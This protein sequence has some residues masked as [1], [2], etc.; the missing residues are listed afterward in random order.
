MV[1]VVGREQETGEDDIASGIVGPLPNLC[2]KHNSLCGK[3]Q[4][5]G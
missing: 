5:G 3:A 2:R 4:N 1:A